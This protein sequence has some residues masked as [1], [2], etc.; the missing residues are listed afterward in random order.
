MTPAEIIYNQPH[1][2]NKILYEYKGLTTPSCIAFKKGTIIN[3]FKNDNAFKDNDS[4]FMQKINNQY[5]SFHYIT[6]YDSEIEDDSLFCYDWTNDYED[7]PSQ[8][9]NNIKTINKI[10]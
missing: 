8:V 5:N 4:I 9:F 6:R 3:L 7:D 10:Y 2:I 1:L